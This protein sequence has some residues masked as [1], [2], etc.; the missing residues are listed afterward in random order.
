MGLVVLE[1]IDKLIELRIEGTPGPWFLTYERA[2]HPRVW[3]TAD[4]DDDHDQ[5]AQA[6]RS[7]NAELI[8][9]LHRTI[10]AQLA[11]LQRFLDQ[12]MPAVFEEPVMLLARSIV[13]SDS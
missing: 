10:D 5:V 4:E 3:G 12:G 7:G 1:A 6:H 13:G 8:V 11:V 9:T 2:T